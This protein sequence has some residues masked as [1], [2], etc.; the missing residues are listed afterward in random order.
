MQQHCT[1]NPREVKKKSHTAERTSNDW[2]DSNS[3][4]LQR[5][6]DFKQ[7]PYSQRIKST[8]FV[9]LESRICHQNLWIIKNAPFLV[10]PYMYIFD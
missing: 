4:A 10:M 7:H 6:A 9:N 8:A 1:W 3:K 5:C 2:I